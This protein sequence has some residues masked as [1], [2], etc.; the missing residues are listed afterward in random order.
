MAIDVDT[1]YDLID[2]CQNSACYID[3]NQ[4]MEKRVKSLSGDLVEIREQK[5]Q[6]VAQFIYQSV[7]DYL[8]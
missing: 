6:R 8:I 4:R 3:T 7:N 1:P 2:E 5:N